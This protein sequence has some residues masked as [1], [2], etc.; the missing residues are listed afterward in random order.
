VPTIR[1]KA[2]KG[3]AWRQEGDQFKLN[4]SSIAKHY[5]SDGSGSLL[6]VV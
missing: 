6:T 4:H 2:E 1:S 3:V 5:I